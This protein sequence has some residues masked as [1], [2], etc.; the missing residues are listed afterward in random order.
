MSI[1]DYNHIRGRILVI[2][3]FK[4]LSDENR[5]RILNVL[6]NDALCVCELEVVLGLTQS[7]VSRHLG[8]LK[9]LGLLRASKDAQWIHYR[10][11]DDFVIKHEAL[12][13]YLKVNFESN[14]LMTMDLSRYKAYKN[15]GY[16]C[17]T[18][19]NDK[20][21]VIEYIEHETGCCV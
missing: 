10:I 21:M 17:Q 7:N 5:L 12:V 20:A 16:N 9:S 13:E 15:S 4:A 3:L 6:M 11:N 2:E 1:S 8:K 19:T 18:I 14:A